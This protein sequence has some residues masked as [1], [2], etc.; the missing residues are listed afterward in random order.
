MVRYMS[1]TIKVAGEVIPYPEPTTASVAAVMRANRRKDTNL[2]VKVRQVLHHRGYRFRKDYLVEVDGLRVRPDIVFTRLRLAVFLD[3]CF[4]HNC[5]EHGNK[6]RVNQPYWEA[7]LAK[8]KA[9]DALVNSRLQDSGWTVLRLW[10]HMTL[11]EATDAVA[12]A[13]AS[14]REAE[15]AAVTTSAT[16][17]G[18]K[19]ASQ[20]SVGL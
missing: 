3:G 14:A 15:Y 8:N 6:P 16:K 10:E 9:R 12:Q 17:C 13:V 11:E 5:P 18:A 19:E 7:K 1:R 2:E 20:S 4:W